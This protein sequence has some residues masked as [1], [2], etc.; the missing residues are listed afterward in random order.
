[1][2]FKSISEDQRTLLMSGIS[3]DDIMR[4][5]IYNQAMQSNILCHFVNHVATKY[6]QISEQHVM[7]QVYQQYFASNLWEIYIRAR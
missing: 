3:Y 5:Q 4:D 6:C 2:Y 1:M 7:P